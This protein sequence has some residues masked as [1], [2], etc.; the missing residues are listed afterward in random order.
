MPAVP[1]L[2]ILRHGQTEWNAE[3]RLQG[4]FDSDLTLKGRQ[5]AAD[6]GAILRRV[7]PHNAIARVSPLPRARATAKIAFSVGGR[8]I[9]TTV[10]ERLIEINLG[11]WQG[12]T[13]AALK[14]IG[15][16]I[17]NNPS[18]Y[19]WKFN[20]PGG[21]TM[22]HMVARCAAVLGALNGPTIL[23]THGVT[24]QVLCSLALGRALSD[25]DVLPDGQGHVHHIKDGQITV[26]PPQS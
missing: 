4:H 21:E 13:T 22:D 18:A 6:Q 9:P 19:L 20:A 5:Q 15:V 3:H 11:A 1:D 16:H 24:S 8:T 26:L 17:P 23:V 14:A 25:R 12:H 2:F 7:L 10:D